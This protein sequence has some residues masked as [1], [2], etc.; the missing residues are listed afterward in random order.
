MT[1]DVR[2]ALRTAAEAGMS[3]TL[4]P[5]VVLALLAGSSEAPA[6][7]AQPAADLEVAA[8]VE[9]FG[10]SRGAGERRGG[11]APRR[12]RGKTDL[13]AWRKARGQAA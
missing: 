8:L 6:P 7:A 9:R 10:R 13:A 5:G 3:L 12:G 1:P 2:A 11:G 4:P